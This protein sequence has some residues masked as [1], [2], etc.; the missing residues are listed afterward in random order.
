M[1][2]KFELKRTY[3]NFLATVLVLRIMYGITGSDL[4]GFGNG[5]LHMRFILLWSYAKIGIVKG[6]LKP[7]I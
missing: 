7:G 3:I 4:D 5:H 6:G 2:E 1:M